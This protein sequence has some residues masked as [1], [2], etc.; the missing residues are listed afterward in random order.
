MIITIMDKIYTIPAGIPF[1]KALASTLL[2]ECRNAPEILAD[3]TILLPTRRACRVLREGFLQCNDGAPLLLPRMQALGDIDEEELSLSLV[4]EQG[5]DAFLNLPSALPALRRQIMLARLIAARA[6]ITYRFDQALALAKALGHFMDQVY[7]EGL[8]MADLTTLV[9]QEFATHWQVTLDF[10]TIISQEWPKI[11]QESNMIDAADRRI[12]LLNILA[13]FWQTHPPQSRIIVAGTTGSIPATA[14]L[15]SII[16]QLPQGQI[17]LP[18]LDQDT[19]NESWDAMGQTHPQFGL[20][21]L[22]NILGCDRDKVL[23]WPTPHIADNDVISSRQ[24]LASELMRPAQSLHH[25][26][27][28]TADMIAPALSNLTLHTCKTQA[29]EALTIAAFMRQTLETPGKTAALITPERSLAAR[30]SAVLQRWDITIDDSAGIPLHQTLHGQFV[31]LLAQACETALSPSAVL[32]MLKHPFCMYREQAEILEISLL[33]GPSPPPGL[34]GLQHVL[35]D[36]ARQDNAQK[37]LCDDLQDMLDALDAA[38]TPLLVFYAQSEHAKISDMLTAHLAACEALCEMSL[39]T[40]EIGTQLAVFLSDF[41]DQAV[42][43]P[44]IPMRDYAGI[45]KQCM[46]EQIFRPAYGT[47]P[48]LQ[49][50]GQLEARLIDA[51]LVILGGLNE[52]SWPPAP[53]HDPW[54]SRPMRAEFGL[55][56]SERGIGLS[57]HDFVQGFCAPHV[58]LTRSEMVEHSPTIPARW[59]VR[60]ETVIRAAG[61]SSNMLYDTEFAH[62]ITILDKPDIVTPALRPAPKPPLGARPRRVSVTKIETWL[63]DPYSLY[64]YYVLNLRPLDALE[65][66]MDAALRGQILHDTLD[67]FITVYPDHIPDNALDI[68]RKTAQDMLHLRHKDPEE[69]RFYWPRFDHIMDDFL[70]REQAW[71]SEHAASFLTEAHGQMTLHGLGGDFILH[72]RADRIDR[73]KDG[74]GAIIDYKSGGQYSMSGMKSG[75]LPQLPLEG[76]ILQATG[77]GDERPMQCGYLGYWVLNGKDKASEVFAAYEFLD[78]L[79]QNLEALIAVFDDPDV[80]YYS[81]PRSAY[82]PRFNDYEHLARMREWAIQDH[83]HEE[84]A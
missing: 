49:I 1:A 50:L 37:D 82:I 27:S 44:D 2:E 10:L 43:F 32:A 56:D 31:I 60:L 74:T 20:K 59:L 61:L 75:A 3:I 24:Y 62:W 25:W 70:L 39:W 81:L 28:L 26:Q 8:D 63:K 21:Q 55:P 14:Q 40:G 46:S 11:L 9:P 35:D 79:Q 72:G 53:G 54:M 68:L 57:A 12:R 45:I 7:T 47:H 73:M 36:Y 64:A 5:I 65:Q 71:R 48:R 76:L 18:G 6:D 77:F 66:D 78:D 41:T 13:E 80:P 34:A 19:D 16:A 84:V 33:R 29:Q 22:L 15:L 17:I 83:D 23:E 69:W 4:Q 58:A 30:V 42:F 52:G 38:L 51:D 67:H